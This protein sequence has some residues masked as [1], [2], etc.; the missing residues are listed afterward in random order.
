MAEEKQR[1]KAEALTIRTQKVDKSSE[2]DRFAQMIQEVKRRKASSG[3]ASSK[4]DTPDDGRGD[5]T[6]KAS[7]PGFKT[8]HS[9]TFAS[10]AD[11]KTIDLTEISSSQ[12]TGDPPDHPGPEMPTSDSQWVGDS[13]C[14]F[15][16]DSEEEDFV[17]PSQLKAMRMPRRSSRRM[18]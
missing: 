11:E 2:E 3:Q 12:N 5:V 16:D 8:P 13:L 1:L 15:V 9:P 7:P 17:L 4:A 6:T 18:C 10:T 14:D